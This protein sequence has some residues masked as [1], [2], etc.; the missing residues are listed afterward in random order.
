MRAHMSHR[1]GEPSRL[2]RAGC[3][4][5]VSLTT[6]ATALARTGRITLNLHLPAAAR[7]TGSYLLHLV[8][9]SPSGKCHATNNLT[10]EIGP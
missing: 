8:T 7:H 5:S 10:L 3:R 4:I 6:F 9:T 2:R 1:N